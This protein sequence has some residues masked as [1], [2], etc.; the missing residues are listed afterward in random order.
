MCVS[1]ICV[2]FEILIEKL[3][4]TGALS[5]PDKYDVSWEAKGSDFKQNKCLLKTAVS[6]I[7]AQVFDCIKHRKV[8]VV[9]IEFG[10]Q[11]KK[12][13]LK[14]FINSSKEWHKEGRWVRE[15]VLI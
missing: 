1:K 10:R 6:D 4:R 8:S 13:G 9:A 3:W 5:Y 2:F 14:G 15:N 7:I 11:R 12:P